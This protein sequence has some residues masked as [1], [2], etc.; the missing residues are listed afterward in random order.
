[1][2]MQNTAL[3]IALAAALL[4]AGCSKDDSAKDNGTEAISTQT[5]PPPAPTTVANAAITGKA[6]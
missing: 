5:A 6:T 4:L 2:S 3:T 1:M